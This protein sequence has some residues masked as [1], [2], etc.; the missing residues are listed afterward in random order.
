MYIFLSGVTP[1]SSLL[2]VSQTSSSSAGSTHTQLEGVVT[3]TPLVG[4]GGHIKP[5][6]GMEL[7]AVP[8]STSGKAAF[9]R[10]KK[11]TKV[12]TPVVTPLTARLED[13][14]E[15]PRYILYNMYILYD[16]EDFHTCTRKGREYRGC[17]GS[18]CSAPVQMPQFV[19][20]AFIWG[21]S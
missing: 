17:G 15:R 10:A 20:T 11:I 12:G 5:E 6:E 4:T 3:S 16:L 18:V 19:K 14:H 13:D 1:S 2:N 8:A 9:S 21:S 7:S